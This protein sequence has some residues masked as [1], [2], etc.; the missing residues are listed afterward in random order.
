MQSMNKVLCNF[1]QGLTELEKYIARGNLGT[2]GMYGIQANSTTHT[3]T[4]TEAQ[5][6]QFFFSKTTTKSGL[7]L[8]SVQLYISPDGTKPN[9][10]VIPLWID[11]RRNYSGGSMNSVIGYTADLVR[12]ENNGP[13]QCRLDI[14]QFIIDPTITSMD[15]II[16]FEDYKI[17]QNTPVQCNASGVLIGNTL[18]TST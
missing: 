18:D 12:I 6:G 13:W 3:V 5:N 17:P 1:A 14:F 8:L 16:S 10:N 7:Y 4:Q 15:F 9:D 2:F 11:V